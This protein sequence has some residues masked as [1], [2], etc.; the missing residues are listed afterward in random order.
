MLAINKTTAVKLIISLNLHEL[1][2]L[3][4][5]YEVGSD[6]LAYL[7]WHHRIKSQELVFVE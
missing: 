5:V 7:E 4:D 3:A 1:L 6:L 2:L